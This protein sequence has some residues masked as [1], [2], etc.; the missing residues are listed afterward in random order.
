MTR[1]QLEW[2]IKMASAL[3]EDYEIVVI[4]SQ[5]L[6]GA[7]PNAPASLVRSMEADLY[8]RHNDEK[9]ELIDSVLGELSPFHDANAFYA[10]AVKRET[11]ILPAGWEGRL[12]KIQNERTDLRVGLCLHPS[13]MAASKLAAGREKDWSFVEEMLKYRIVAVDEMTQRVT[14]LPISEE[15]KASLVLWLESRVIPS[16]PA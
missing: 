14:D 12:V 2:L 9:G 3:T 5:S 13:D 11:A 16:D 6:L 8:P 10:Q 7:V 4:G 1:E 15:R